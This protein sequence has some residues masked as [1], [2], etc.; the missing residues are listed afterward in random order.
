VCTGLV[1]GEN[2]LESHFT[3]A[4]A[5]ARSLAARNQ[6]YKAP[7]CWRTF[8]TNRAVAPASLLAIYS[9]YILAYPRTRSLVALFLSAPHDFDPNFWFVPS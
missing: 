2:Q 4:T 9:L 1:L 6:A 7:R 5:T 8:N 3:T